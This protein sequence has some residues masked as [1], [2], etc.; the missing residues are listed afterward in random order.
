MI[1]TI[2]ESILL[3]VN[4]IAILNE[5]RFLKKCKFNNNKDGF[6][7][8]AAQPGSI[9]EKISSKNQLIMMVF[10]LRSVGKCKVKDIS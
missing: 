5:K 4:A 8:S 3:I 2:L 9:N 7:T 1:L 6:D 10:T